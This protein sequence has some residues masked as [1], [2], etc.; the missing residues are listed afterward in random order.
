MT[1]WRFS[2][3]KFKS[4]WMDGSATFTIETSSTTIR[5]AMPSTASAFHRFGSGVIGT[6]SSSFF[7]FPGLTS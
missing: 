7:G 6:S 4:V 1:H 3:E 5:Y 2:G